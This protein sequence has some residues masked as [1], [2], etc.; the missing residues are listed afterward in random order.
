A[1]WVR[2][3]FLAVFIACG[4][5]PIFG[6][7]SSMAA[8]YELKSSMWTPAAVWLLSLVL[9]VIAVKRPLTANEPHMKALRTI[10]LATYPIYLIH[11]VVGAAMISY[12]VRLGIEQ[13]I[14]LIIVM[15]C[16]VGISVSLTVHVEA[17]MVWILKRY[18]PFHRPS[19][20]RPLGPSL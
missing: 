10:G 8:H 18:D 4:V 15:L 11:D 12:L 14:S 20:A 9:I 19:R 1:T 6:E 17:R 3:I 13:Q 5:I 16:V 2:S 7:A